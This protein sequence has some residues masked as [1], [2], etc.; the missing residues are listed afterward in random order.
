MIALPN[1]FSLNPPCAGIASS[2]VSSPGSVVPTAFR[3][4]NADA[5]SPGESNSD[6][7]RRVRAA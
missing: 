4:A 1:P 2:G 7:L 5:F 3:S 6:F